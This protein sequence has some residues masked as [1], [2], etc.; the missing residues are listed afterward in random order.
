[1]SLRFLV[2]VTIST[3]LS[4]CVPAALKPAQVYTLSPFE[5]NGQ[6]STNKPQHNLVI[7]LMPVR[8]N[9]PFTST[10]LIYSDREHTHNKYAFSRWSEAP[11]RMLQTYLQAYLESSE[12]FSA[13]VLAKSSSQSALILESRLLDFSH[14]MLN[15]GSS[16]G[17]IRMRFHLIDSATRAVKASHEIVA[18]VPAPTKNAQGAVDSLNMAAS[19]LGQKLVSWLA[20][21]AA[22]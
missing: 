21:V 12:L 9:R 7:K 6:L 14:H 13:V 5:Q 10:S 1:V 2:I 16:V 4:G 15:D 20:N 3:I 17:V 8:G 22:L 19:S 11:V 18:R